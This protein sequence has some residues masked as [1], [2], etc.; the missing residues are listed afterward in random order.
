[1]NASYQLMHRLAGAQV[2]GPILTGTSKSVHVA[3]RDAAVGDIVNLTAIAVL[4]AQRKSRNST[5]A[6]EIERSF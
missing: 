2:I 5:L 3:Q 6:A 1:A 4:D